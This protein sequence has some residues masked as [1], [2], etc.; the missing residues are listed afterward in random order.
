MKN[1]YIKCAEGKLRARRRICRA[2]GGIA[3]CSVGGFML[4]AAEF[5]GRLRHG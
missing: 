3:V 2:Y 5:A 1:T 4:K